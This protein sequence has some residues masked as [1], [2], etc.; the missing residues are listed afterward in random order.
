M[1]ILL[2]LSAA[3]LIAAV[4]FATLGPPRY[5]PQSPLGQDC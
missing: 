4:V 3:V 1:K 5:R 2:R